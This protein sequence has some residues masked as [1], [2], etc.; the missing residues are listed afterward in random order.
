MIGDNLCAGFRS[1]LFYFRSSSAYN[2]LSKW[3]WYYYAGLR[4]SRCDL[5]EALRYF[6][7]IRQ[8]EAAV[9]TQVFETFHENDYIRSVICHHAASFIRFSGSKE[10]FRDYRGAT[11][12]IVNRSSCARAS[13]FH[14]MMS[15]NSWAEL[16]KSNSLISYFRMHTAL[17]CSFRHSTAHV[18]KA[19]SPV[20][21]FSLG[22]NAEWPC[23]SFSGA[24]FHILRQERW[25]AY[26]SDCSD[27]RGWGFI[28]VC[29]HSIR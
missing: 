20:W 23:L 11:F 25:Q 18:G 16:K 21:P 5:N 24:L 13:R 1:A 3:R 27:G 6:F 15:V 7:I 26:G 8:A 28:F 9:N 12:L 14:K 19:Y 22:W 29:L 2:T 10:A 17:W 4:I